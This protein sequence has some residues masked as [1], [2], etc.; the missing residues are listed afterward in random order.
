MK[1]NVVYY[2]LTEH[3]EFF[4]LE[5]CVCVFITLLREIARFVS[6]TVKTLWISYPFCQQMAKCRMF[7]H[8]RT[9]GRDGLLWIGMSYGL[10]LCR[11]LQDILSVLILSS[12]WDAVYVKTV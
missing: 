6:P 10:Q 2:Q 4:F 9:G 7:V 12:W 3:A 5:M 1:T 8:N 11:L